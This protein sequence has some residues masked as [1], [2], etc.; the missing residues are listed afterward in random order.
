MRKD[1]REGVRKFMNDGIKPNFAALARQYGCDYRT[2]KAAC[3]AETQYPEKKRRVKRKSKLDEFKPIIHDK[4]EIQCSAYSIFKFIEKKGY[5]GSY[6]LVK[7]YCRKERKTRQKQATMC[8]THTSGLAG[9]VDWK[10]DMTLISRHGEIFRFNIFLYV[11]SFSRK[12]YITLTF[13]RHQDT[14][15]EC[16]DDAFHHTGGVPGE[17]WFDNMR[18][19]V[20]QSSTQYNK[21]MFNQRFYAFS[22]DAAFQP[23]ACRPYRPQTKGMVEALARTMDRLRV[24]NHEFDDSVDLIHIVHDLCHELNTEV[25]QATDA[26]PDALWLDKEKEHLHP[27]PEDLLKPYFEDQLTRVVSKEAMVQFRK[28][29]YS[30]DPQYIGKTVEIE[31]S[32]T[33][34]NIHIYYNGE[35]VRSHLL[36]TQRFNYNQ[37][38]M[39]NILK[40]DL[41]A[42]RPDD[43]IH[44]YIHESL[45]LYDAVGDD[46][47]E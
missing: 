7:Q 23:I 12:K 9:Q 31:L 42:G 10:E 19:V 39:F 36:T 14:L 47:H 40:S 8:V 27:L 17:I 13:D 28:C 45:Q 35:T 16:L 32:D 21:V 37:A 6:S 41:L 15:F 11:L 1:V 3:E 43:D 29:K 44:E 30:V 24:Y 2:V 25:S 26:I 22:K 5:D 4:L 18:T 34:D 38:D 46:V 33:E 20:D